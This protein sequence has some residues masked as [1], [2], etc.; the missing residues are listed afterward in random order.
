L[1][2]TQ[3]VEALGH[4]AE[5]VDCARAVVHRAQQLGVD[6]PIAQSVVGL[7]D[8]VLSPQQAVSQLM[9]RGAKQEL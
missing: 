5:G 1:T 7:L 6:M 9:G 4:V 8:G 3:A 2:V